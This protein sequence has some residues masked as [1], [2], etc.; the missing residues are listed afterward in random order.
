M[1][2][3]PHPLALEIHAVANVGL[4]RIVAANLL[5]M[6]LNAVA[7]VRHVGIGLLLRAIFGDREARELLALRADLR[8]PV[9]HWDRQHRLGAARAGVCNEGIASFAGSSVRLRNALEVPVV[10]AVIGVLLPVVAAR[11]VAAHA[12][13]RGAKVT[14]LGGRGVGE[15]IDPGID[16]VAICGCVHRNHNGRILR[17]RTERRRCEDGK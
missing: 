6:R 3:V 14:K 16:L 5:S 15:S 7:G 4:R 17:P 13:G 1:H 10:G 8:E 9:D 11:V 12:I 2:Q